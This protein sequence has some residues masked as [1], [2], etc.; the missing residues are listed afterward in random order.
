MENFNNPKKV[1]AVKNE[2]VNNPAKNPA[3]FSKNL[4]N[5]VLVEVNKAIS[6]PS[7]KTIKKIVVNKERSKTRLLNL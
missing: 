7:R 1:S 6:N 3:I 5:K 4:K 2:L